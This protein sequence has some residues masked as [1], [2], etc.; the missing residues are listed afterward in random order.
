MCP[1]VVTSQSPESHLTG[2]HQNLSCPLHLPK[3]ISRAGTSGTLAL[4]WFSG[5]HGKGS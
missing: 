5:T 2:G 1:V 4:M 3:S